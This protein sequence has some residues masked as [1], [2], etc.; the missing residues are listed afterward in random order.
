MTFSKKYFDFTKVVISG[1]IFYQIVIDKYE[2]AYNP[3]GIMNNNF[4]TSGGFKGGQEA[5]ALGPVL[6]VANKGPTVIC[7]T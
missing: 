6:L 4:L 7:G 5:M 1:Y 2:V 3:H